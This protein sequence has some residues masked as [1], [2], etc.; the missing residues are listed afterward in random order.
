MK[1]TAL[2]VIA[3]QIIALGCC[4]NKMPT[5]SKKKLNLLYNDDPNLLSIDVRQL[6]ENPYEAGAYVGKHPAVIEYK[7]KD[8]KTR[9]MSF[10]PDGTLISDY[11][12]NGSGKLLR[13]EKIT[14]PTAR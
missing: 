6:P 9:V 10:L 1:V 2:I 11:R 7:F 12:V 13:P 4:S 8:G 5:F 14:Q 3:I